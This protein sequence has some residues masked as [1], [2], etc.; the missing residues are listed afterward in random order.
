MPTTDPGRTVLRQ[1]AATLAYRAAKVLRDAPAGFG[2][3]SFGDA[4]RQPVR[5][6]AHMADLMTWGVSI[7]GGGREWKP[8]GGDD[9][10][11]EVDRFF[12]GLAA[13]DAAMAT[14]GEFKGSIDQ[15]IQG[16][17]ADALT[18]VGQLSM[19]RG[20]A[21]APVKPESYARAAITRGRVGLDQEKPKAEF[22]GDASARRP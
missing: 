4:T 3:H 8:A 20:M 11:T 9:W 18:H 2:H 1:L 6:V 15:L 22:D 17:L 5:I 12:T 19:L 13:L 16:P 10:Q 21:G 14:E 7:A